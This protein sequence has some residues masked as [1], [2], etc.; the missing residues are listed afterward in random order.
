[1]EQGDASSG[2]NSVLAPFIRRRSWDIIRRWEDGARK[3]RAARALSEPALLDHVPH[4]LE[5]MARMAEELAQGKRS[6]PAVD[7]IERHAL[8]R[9][10][11]GFDIS[12]VVAEFSM[13][14]DSIMELFV[15]E[16]PHDEALSETRLLDQSIDGAISL[17]VVRYAEARDRTLRALDRISAAALDARGVDEFLQRLVQVMVDTTPAVDE[18]SV[19]LDEHGEA[20]IAARKVQRAGAPMATYDLPL[21]DGGTRFGHVRMSST[22]AGQF[23][24]Q[25]KQLLQALAR[26]AVAGLVQHVLREQSERSLVREREARARLAAVLEAIPDALYIGDATGVKHANSAGLRMLGLD[27]VDPIAQDI[28]TASARINARHPD[29]GRPLTPDEH[30]FTRALAGETA[31]MDVL[32]TNQAS[33]EELVVRSSAA[34]IRS[35]D[36]VVGAVAINADVTARRFEEERQ[37]LLADIGSALVESMAVDEIK[38]GIARRLLPSFADHVAIEVWP[39]EQARSPR[40]DTQREARRIV[41]ALRARRCVV[42]TLALERNERR[43]PFS[44]DDVLLAQEVGRRGGLAVDNALLHEALERETLFRERFIAILGH[45]LRNPVH[46]VKLSAD[47]L[48][49]EHGTARTIAV[50]R[51]IERSAAR[52]QHML[53]NLVDF[54]RVRIAGERL[55][56]TRVAGR[57]ED[58]VRSVVE[59]LETAHPGR[60][61]RMQVVGD[62][63]GSW[64]TTRLAQLASNLVGNAF[65]HGDARAPVTVTL[66]G[67]APEVVRLAVHNA[68]KAIP[69]SVKPHLFDPFRRG[70][71]AQSGAADK[72]LGL[73]LFIVDQVAQAHGGSV[74]VTSSLEAG[75]TFAVSLPRAPPMG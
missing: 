64:D 25:D 53:D 66:D 1:M 17:S 55:R 14:R 16:M 34:P 2:E 26:R 21:E 70:A 20:R 56:L 69:D 4:I 47:A 48:L 11:E 63:S 24:E 36:R 67:Q 33:K 39:S 5:D 27:H 54:T 29:T 65:K 6:Q 3:N 52:M 62:S 75:T 12:Q 46:A 51:R 38:D 49:R 41:V 7:N 8:A 9:L 30:V 37:R 22:S 23:S 32:V 28:A 68:G 44:D 59:E 57:L 60:V 18:V 15:A 58:I 31:T 45:D 74:S 42:G 50:A 13:L 61:V 73:G 10:E 72:S 35:G 19:I 43:R 71:G 40:D